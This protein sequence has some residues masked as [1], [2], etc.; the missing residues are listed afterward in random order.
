MKIQ[1]KFSSF[2][3]PA[4]LLIGKWPNFGLSAV[5]GKKFL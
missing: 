1:E 5:V 2:F 3:H 4:L